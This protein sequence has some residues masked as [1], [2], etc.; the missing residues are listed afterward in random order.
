LQGEL[1]GYDL[2]GGA[3]ACHSETGILEEEEELPDGAGKDDVAIVNCSSAG[4]T[5]NQLNPEQSPQQKRKQQRR[6]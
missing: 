4:R 1:F 3:A 5:L 6:L 2:G